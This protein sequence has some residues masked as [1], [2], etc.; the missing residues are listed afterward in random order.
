[1][2]HEAQDK[3]KII[4]ASSIAK[5]ERF[6]WLISKCTELGVDRICPVIFEWTVKQAKG[7]TILKRYENLTIAAAKQSQRIFLPR[8]DNPCPF[9]ESLSALQKELPGAEILFGSPSSKASPLIGQNFAAQKDTIAFIGPEGGMTEQE[10]Q[11]LREAGGR[12]VRLTD[13]ILR[14][15][16]A[17]VCF[18]SILAAE[19]LTKTD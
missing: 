5:G 16:T 17:A 4:I 3:P 1:V 8:I 7:E 12:E 15:E 13:T 9:T 6:D 18:A 14:I 10:E 2:I 19:R 11:L